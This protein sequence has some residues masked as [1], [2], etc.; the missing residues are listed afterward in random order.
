MTRIPTVPLLLGLGGLIPF[1]WGALT[2]VA[3][4]PETWSQSVFGFRFTS[5][6]LLQT[7]GIVIL[8][9]MSG[10]VWGFATRAEGILAAR[11]YALSVLPALW[12]FFLGTGMRP[13]SLWALLIGFVALL[14]VDAT[15][16][17][18]GLAPAW[19]L[20][21]R[22]LL[23]AIVAACLVAGAVAA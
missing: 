3:P 13:L 14:A 22:L 10:V 8:S 9:F 17:R 15:A 11:L 5:G 4:G 18:H 23:T 19:W 12:A 16:L 1:L 2:S 6:P 20:S 7:Y 21:L